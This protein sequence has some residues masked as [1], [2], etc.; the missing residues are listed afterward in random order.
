MYAEAVCWRCPGRVEC[1]DYAAQV[2]LWG[3][4]GAPTG[5]PADQPATSR[6]DA[7]ETRMDYEYEEEWRPL[8]R[9]GIAMPTH[10]LATGASASAP[11]RRLVWQEKSRQLE[12]GTCSAH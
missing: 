12:P 9:W 3:L 11:A 4:F 6:P 8:S 5:I 10:G 2:P 1:A 7:K